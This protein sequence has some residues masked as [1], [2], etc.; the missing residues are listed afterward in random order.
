MFYVALARRH[1]A[2]LAST[3]RRL[4]RMAAALGVKSGLELLDEG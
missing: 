1:D 3:D 2:T 4:L